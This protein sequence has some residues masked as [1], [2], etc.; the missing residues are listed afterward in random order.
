MSDASRVFRSINN[1]L[2]KMYPGEPRGNVARHLT[3]L[4]AMICGIVRS[5]KTHLPAIAGDVPENSKPDSRVKKY[6]RWL[7]NKHISQG[8]FFL[9]FAQL[10]I[11]SLAH[12]TLVLAIDGSTVGRGCVALMVSIIYKG[13]ALPIAWLVVAGKK[14]H[15]HE[16]MHIELLEQVH[17]LIPPNK[18]VVFLGDGEF[19]GVKLLAA[20]DKYHWQ[21]VCRTAKNTTVYGKVF[22][23]RSLEDLPI[24]PGK[25]I[26]LPYVAFTKRKYSPVHAIAWWE[27]GYEEPIYLVTN[28]YFMEDACFW[29]RKRFHIETFFKDAKSQGFHLHKSHISDPTRL[30]RLMIAACLAYIWI[31]YLGEFAMQ[32]FFPKVIHRAQRCDLSLFQLGL[33]SLKHFLMQQMLNEGEI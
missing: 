28:I 1:A 11:A 32:T 19:D 5:Q 7:T 15:F 13:R 3:T 31:V 26:C 30:S 9:P 22:G 29:Y 24:S 2:R 10:L 4:A 8:I 33:R 16:Q 12:E 6:S 17:E 25:C 14:G 21:Y 27:K 18:K 20:L 23:K